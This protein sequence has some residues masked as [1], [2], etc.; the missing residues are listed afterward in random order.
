M[1][2][3]LDFVAALLA[4]VRSNWC[5]DDKRIYATGSVDSFNLHVFLGADEVASMSNGGGFVGTI[6]CSPLGGEFAAF[7]P[8]SGSFYTDT[9]GPDNGCAPARKPLP[10]LEFHGGSDKSVAYTGGQGEGGI[11]PSIPDWYV[12]IA[13][14]VSL[15]RKRAKH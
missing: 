8:V 15:G 4:D 7:A 11:E 10:M 2:E 3:D 9:N 5:V 14:L 1:Q 6:A 13:T 12:N